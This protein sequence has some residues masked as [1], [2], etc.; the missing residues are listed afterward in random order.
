LDE[1]KNI[2]RTNSET[3]NNSMNILKYAIKNLNDAPHVGLLEGKKMSGMLEYKDKNGRK[4]SK[5]TIEELLIYHYE[6]KLL[7]QFLGDLIV[8]TYKTDDPKNQS[9]WTRHYWSLQTN[10]SYAKLL[11]HFKCLNNVWNSDISRLTFIIKEL[12]GKSSKWVADKKG[13]NFTKYVISPLTEKIMEIL[14]EYVKKCNDKIQQIGHL[15]DNTKN[16]TQK[17]LQNMEK[18]N[19]V[20]MMINLKKINI[21]ILK[22]I[23][24]FFNLD[25]DKIN[26]LQ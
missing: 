1:Y 15:D 25:V 23:S 17:T 26:S 3:I 11:R 5:H 14:K 6:K 21:E 18:A 7:H 24:P 22:Y 19:S 4:K 10:N 9:I 20:I 8:D 13:L 2:T 12:I 16:D